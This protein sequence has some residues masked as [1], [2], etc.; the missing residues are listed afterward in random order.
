M[1]S[2]EN[3]E[4]FTNTDIESMIE[5]SFWKDTLYEIISIM[6]P[7]DIDI[8]ELATHYSKRVEQMQEMNFR[9]PANV[10]IVCSVLLRMKSEIMGFG[11]NG[12]LNP[13]EFSDPEDMGEFGYSQTEGRCMDGGNGE[14]FVPL[15]ITPRRVPKRRVTAMELIAAIQQVLEDR[16][17]RK[18]ISEEFIEKKTIVINL[19]ADIRQLIKETYNRVMDILSRKD[20]VLFSELAN[21]RDEIISTFVSLLHLSNK[22]KL[23]LTQRK[24]FDEIYIHA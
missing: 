14:I 16:I 13:D 1:D 17:I 23:K 10:I 7:W 18:K 24:I 8:V 21:S 4:N 15:E 20:V 6:N 22:Q 5:T 12:S 11:G 9:I 19:D 3:I 2:I